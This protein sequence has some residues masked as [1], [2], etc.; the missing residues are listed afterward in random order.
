MERINVVKSGLV[1]GMLLGACH[2]LWA[3]L[4]A[5]GWAQALLNFVF[6]MHFLKPIY[7]VGEFHVGIALTLIAITASIGFVL[8]SA[9]A[10]MWN[11]IQRQ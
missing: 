8:G 7:V 5:L 11:G 9:F 10:Y 2:L 6:W 3:A 1:F 4:V